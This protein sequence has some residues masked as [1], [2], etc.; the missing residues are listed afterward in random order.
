MRKNFTYRS[1]E[2][3]YTVLDP[4]VGAKVTQLG[5]VGRGVEFFFIQNLIFGK[6]LS[7]LKN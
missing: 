1:L 4:G 2:K 6:Y 3:L 5:A 7:A